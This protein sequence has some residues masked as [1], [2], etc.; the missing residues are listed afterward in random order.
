MNGWIF[1]TKRGTTSA[2]QKIEW[3]SIAF[4]LRFTYKTWKIINV[5]HLHAIH[6]RLRQEKISV[7][8]LCNFS[9]VDDKK[10]Q[11]SN[12]QAIWSRIIFVN[13]PVRKYFLSNQPAQG[14]L[15]IYLVYVYI[16]TKTRQIRHWA[17]EK[18][19][20]ISHL[21]SRKSTHF[22]MDNNY[23]LQ[24]WFIVCRCAPYFV[25]PPPWTTSAWKS[26]SKDYDVLVDAFVIVKKIRSQTIG[27]T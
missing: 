22:C 15:V 23:V 2:P 7:N 19:I 26:S 16:T 4:A 13:I 20:Y 9:L 8:N 6:P 17:E 21:F 27:Q 1:L 14:C 11:K 10:D 18:F 3:V 5:F 25:C 24:K 12:K